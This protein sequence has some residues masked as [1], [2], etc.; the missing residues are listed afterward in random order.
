M[1]VHIT[2]DLDERDRR[3]IAAYYGHKGPADYDTCRGFIESEMAATL[4]GMRSV[5]EQEDWERRY[6]ETTDAD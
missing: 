4:E 1:Q 6:E 3:R 2:F 5:E